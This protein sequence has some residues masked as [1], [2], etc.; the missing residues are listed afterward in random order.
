PFFATLAGLC[1]PL[2]HQAVAWSHRAVCDRLP[3]GSALSKRDRARCSSLQCCSSTRSRDSGQSHV[4][5]VL[6]ASKRESYLADQAVFAV[7]PAG[8]L[9]GSTTGWLAE[10]YWRLTG[11]ASTSPHDAHQLVPDTAPSGRPL[12]RR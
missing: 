8:S 12:L 7:Y 6:A 2:P 4:L 1:A 5:L 3:D 11:A 9:L 10:E